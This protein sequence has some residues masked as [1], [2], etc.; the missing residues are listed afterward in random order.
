MDEK[1]KGWFCERLGKD[2]TSLRGTVMIRVGAV[3]IDT[4]HPMGFADSMK[5]DGRMQYV[6]VYND[7]FRNDKEVEGF[8]ARYGLEKRCLSIEELAEMCDIGFTRDV[9][10]MIIYVVRSRL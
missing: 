2:N 10:G 7:S 5:K 4:S 1:A 8:I 3:N 6:G 9:I